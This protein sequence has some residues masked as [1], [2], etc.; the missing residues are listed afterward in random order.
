MN[1]VAA[2]LLGCDPE[3]VVGM[4]L[5]EIVEAASR[6]NLHAHLEE[7]RT[8]AQIRRSEVTTSDI[9]G[10]LRHVLLQT[11]SHLDEN[12]ST[13]FQV[14]L[15][16]VTP[17]VER[18]RTMESAGSSVETTS[19]SELEFL[20]SL[21]HEIRSS[22]ASMI[23]FAEVLKANA[24]DENED[25]ADIIIESGRHLLDTLNSVI[26][27]ARPNFDR[28]DMEV[29]AIDVVERVRDRMASFRPSAEMRGLVLEFRAESDSAVAEVN[30]TFLDRIIY[31]LIDNA[32]KYTP[33]GKV[34]VSVEEREGQVWIYIADTGMGIDEGFMPKLFT[35]FERERRSAGA[36]ADGIGIGL[37]ITK[38]LTELMGGRVVVCSTKGEGSTFTVSFPALA[39]RQTEGEG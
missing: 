18:L 27:L 3:T 32:I 36:S 13:A 19:H 22:L 29:A 24:T 33:R 25:L 14:A 4:P 21:S 1:S 26:D 8:S 15:T 39:R 2:D 30:V 34:E 17:Y 6:S 16:D 11:L 10:Q 23:G 9:N 35:P 28:E 5:L 37:S 7:A 20:V 38:R 31:N 12:G